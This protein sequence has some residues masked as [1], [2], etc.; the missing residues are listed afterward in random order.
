MRQRQVAAVA[1]V[2]LFGLA[3]CADRPNDLEHY[4]DDPP[5]TTSVTPPL[6]PKVTPSERAQAAPKP[7]DATTTQVSAVL[8]SDED[9]AAEG[10]HPGAGSASGCLTEIAAGTR[11]TATWLYPSGSVLTHEVT[12]YPG[13]RGADVLAETACEGKKQTLPDQPGV[14]AQQAWW[15]GHACVVLLAKG[16]VVSA[17]SVAAS[18]ETRARDAAK[19]LLPVVAAK[20]AAQP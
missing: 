2:A 16:N 12:G 5:T 7:P 11:R 8:L 20:L 9:V 4:Y 18:T 17:L 10:V 15:D 3:G 1:A 19:R 14:D 6:T 13:R